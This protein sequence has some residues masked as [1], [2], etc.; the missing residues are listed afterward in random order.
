M[1]QVCFD[2]KNVNDLLI[3]QEIKK[4]KL[5]IKAIKN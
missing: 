2:N 1:N 3:K 5:E 4:Q